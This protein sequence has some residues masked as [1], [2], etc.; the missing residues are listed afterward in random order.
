[1]IT[2][3]KLASIAGLALSLAVAVGSAHSSTLW[4]FEDDD[5][6]FALRNGVVI[7]SGTISV[8]DVLVSAVQVP[9]FT[10]NGVP[11]IPAG[12]EMTGVAAIQLLRG[13]GS[14]IN[15]YVFVPVTNGLNS[16]LALAGLSVTVTGGE[17]GQG[18]MLAL[19]LNATGAGTDRDLELNRSILAAT[20]CTSFS[21]C[22]DQATRGSLFQVDGFVG[23]VDEFWISTLAILGGGDIATVLGTNNSLIVANVNFALST[24][25]NVVNPVGFI[26]IATGL[27]C[28][29][30]GYVGDGCVQ[31]QGSS[32]ITGGQGLSNGAFAHSDFDAQKYVGVPEP[33]TLALLGIGLLAGVGFGASRRKKKVAA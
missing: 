20:N 16:I 8:G 10:I 11:S 25:F 18:A 19:F 14:L 5:I 27:E 33:G 28:A 29:A 2:I 7:T 17:A 21:D 12:Q 22:V 26:N 1:M 4:S 32:T 15:P 3:K 31:F 6:D 30:A 23:D 9:Q 13:D 24:L